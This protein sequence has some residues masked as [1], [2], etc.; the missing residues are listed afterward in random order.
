[1]LPLQCPSASKTELG[2]GASRSNCS[3]GRGGQRKKEKK[4]EEKEEEDEER[5]EEKGYLFDTAVGSRQV[6]SPHP[7]KVVMEKEEPT[8]KVG[9]T[10]HCR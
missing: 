4:E 5:K 1:M 8:K 7:S 6:R 3:A 9:S 2:L 10:M